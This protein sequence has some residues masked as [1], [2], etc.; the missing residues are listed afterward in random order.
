LLEFLVAKPTAYQ[1]ELALFL[2]DEFG[3][4]TSRMTISRSLK[5]LRVSRKILQREA[6][7]RSQTLRDHWMSRLSGWTADQLVFIDESAANERSA[8]RKYGWAPI[9][10]K[11][12]QSVPLK[13]SERYSV[14]P[15]YTV[16]G[17]IAWIIH[18]GAVSGSIFNEF[19]H[20]YVLPL[21]NEYPGPRS[22]L[23]MDNASIHRSEVCYY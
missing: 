2:W 12:I 13:H 1:D 17:Y 18:Q 9:G 3:V 19:I 8:D 14:L 21:C 23:C 6:A 15:A 20:E 10:Q 11:A 5:R 7:Q 22:V 4:H 16:D